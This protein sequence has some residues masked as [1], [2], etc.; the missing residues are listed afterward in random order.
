MQITLK[1]EK[2][3]M[4]VICLYT[5]RFPTWTVKKRAYLDKPRNHATMTFCS[6]ISFISMP[7]F[8]KEERKD[9]NTEPFKFAYNCAYSEH[10]R[11]MCAVIAS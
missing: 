1:I 4:H 10:K 9:Y 5:N 6:K 3:N 7:L 2:K 8:F 11:L